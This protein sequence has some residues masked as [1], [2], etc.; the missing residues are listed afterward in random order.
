MFPSVSK[1]TSSVLECVLADWMT[2]WSDSEHVPVRDKDAADK[3]LEED[4]SR[5]KCVCVCVCVCGH[6]AEASLSSPA[7]SRGPEQNRSL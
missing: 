1:H 4:V 7:V 6:T 3:C 5:L 2:R